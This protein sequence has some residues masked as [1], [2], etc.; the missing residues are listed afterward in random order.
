MICDS[1]QKELEL[2][3][4]SPGKKTCKG[5]NSEKAKAWYAKN[6]VKRAAYSKAHNAQNKEANASRQ[7]RYHEANREILLVKKRAKHLENRDKILVKKRDY[8]LQNRDKILKKAARY[9]SLNMS[10]MVAYNRERARRDSTFRLIRN[11][12]NRTWQAVKGLKSAST[13]Q[14]LGCSPQQVRDH[15]ESLFKPGM[16]WDNYGFRGW[17]VDHIKPLASFDLTD[18]AQQKLAFHYT[19]LQPLWASENFAKGGGR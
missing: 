1:C 16:S 6:R 15:L 14:L 2:S 8:Y 19:N 12:R 17:H 10:K 9:R 18:S 13:I 4:F 7:K 5:C 11:L 3:G